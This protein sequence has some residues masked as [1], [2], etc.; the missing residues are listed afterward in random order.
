[1]GKHAQVIFSYVIDDEWHNQI[2]YLADPT[3]TKSRYK[4]RLNQK[5]NIRSMHIGNEGKK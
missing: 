3:L 1:M 4:S 2:N 5:R